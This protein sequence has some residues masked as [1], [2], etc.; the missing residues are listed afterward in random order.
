M[1]SFMKF[2]LEDPIDNKLA[3]DLVLP[4]LMGYRVS[5]FC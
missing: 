4:S 5:V 2:V 1:Q 3:L